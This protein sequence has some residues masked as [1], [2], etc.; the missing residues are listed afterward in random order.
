MK[1]EVEPPTEAVLYGIK[2]CDRCRKALLWLKSHNQPHCFHDLRSDGLEPSL[3][4]AWI[5]AIGWESLLN[6][7]STT[8]RE[9]PA[10]DRENLDIQRATDLMLAHPTLIKR[11]ILGMDGRWILGFS[12]EHYSHL[13]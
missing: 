13:L 4:A 11:P 8:W 5:N 7:K 12:P 6:R 2:T 9:L 3:L 1:P 10:S